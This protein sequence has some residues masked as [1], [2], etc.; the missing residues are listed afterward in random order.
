MASRQVSV[1]FGSTALR[2]IEYTE[3]KKGNVTVHGTHVQP[4]RPGVIHRGRVADPE[5]LTAVLKTLKSE[6]GFK[7]KDIVFGLS[8]NAVVVRRAPVDWQPDKF[9]RQSLPYAIP[10]G[11]LIEDVDYQ[12]DYHPLG[13][14]V[15]TLA[16]GDQVR[17]VQVLIVA[18][19]TEVVQ[20]YIDTIRAA[21]L[22]PSRADHLGF[23]L[24]RLAA[25]SG[26]EG[27]E[28]VV[29]IG[30]QATNMVLH[31][32]GQPLFVRHLSKGLEAIVDELSSQF[33]WET[34]AAVQ[35]LQALGVSTA[36][37][38]SVVGAGAFG[39]EAP[40][41][42]PPHPAQPIIDRYATDFISEIRTSVDWFLQNSQTISS[43]DRV[44]LSGG[45]AVL[46]GM[47]DRIAAE[48]H[49]PI[50]VAQPFSTLNAK[51]VDISPDDAPRWATA[52]GLA[53][54]AK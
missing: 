52:A 10:D 30:S 15:D 50:E 54:G 44:I 9:F 22:R 1:D 31:L 25:R 51:N 41:E 39:A 7:A 20:G 46:P 16:N 38:M 28:A 47:A 24:T 19:E 13:E 43:L 27:V 8:N 29:D 40:Q 26:R 5:E 23:A 49:I 18:A 35:A 21:G 33:G 14:Y 53:T 11:I 3:D 12:I 32:G 2:A 42:E 6:A 48:L 37:P 45:G 34:A 36:I 4:L 17:R